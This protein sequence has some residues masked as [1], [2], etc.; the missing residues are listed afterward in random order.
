MSMHAPASREELKAYC[1]RQL[2]DPVIEINLSP[3]QEEDAIELSIQF[4]QQFHFDAVEM[5][6][7]KHE[8]TANDISNQ[9]I[10]V[11]DAVVSVARVLPFSA[12]TRGIDLFDI[13]YQILLNDIYSIQST[14]L[15]Y[16]NQV[17]MQ[18]QLINDLLV[19]EKPVRFN[20]HM[21]R[22]FVDMDWPTDIA[23]GEFL[24]IE[25]YRILDPN[26]FTDVYND[27]YLKKYVTAQMKKTWGN[28]LKKFEGVQ[29]PGGVT[30][31]GQRIYDEAIEE[32]KELEAEVESRYQLPVD[33]FLD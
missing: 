3:E 2:G 17:K 16:Y 27:L 11:S 6:Y 12:R 15:I 24:I 20:R 25:A 19:G 18:L 23:E 14:D 28:N 13:R 1:K 32:I 7:L 22:L 10:T 33:F 9:Y 29:L 4:F 30:L 5:V 31:N 26:Q 8:M 21:N